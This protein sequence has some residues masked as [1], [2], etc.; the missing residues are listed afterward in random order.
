MEPAIDI[1]SSE[2]EWDSDELAGFDEIEE[3]SEPIDQYDT[4]LY[5][6]LTIGD[7]LDERYKIVHKLGW[8]GCSTVWMA[9]DTRE[10]KY[11]ALKILTSSRTGHTHGESDAIN[12]CLQGERKSNLVTYH[13]MFELPAGK[14]LHVHRVLVLPL[15]GPN[16]DQTCSE[17]P[18][19]THMHYRMSAAWQ[20]L[21]C[22]KDLHEAKIVH[23]GAAMWGLKCLDEY[24]TNEIYRRL[25]QPRHFGLGGLWKQ[26]DLVK[27]MTVPETLREDNI[28]LGDFGMAIKADT[29]VNIKIQTPATFCAPERFHATDPSF[30]SDMWSYMCIFAWLYLGYHPVR[31]DGGV[32]VISSMV[33]I[34]GPLPERWHGDFKY[35]GEQGD[36]G[37][38]DQSKAP[39]EHESLMSMAACRQ[40]PVSTEEQQLVV[41]IFEK[42][43]RYEPTYRWTAVQLL[44]DIDFIC[45]MGRYIPGFGG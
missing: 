29:A 4:K 17:M 2:E 36:N 24:D 28:C 26:G 6:P 8:G 42:V 19:S 43:F 7:V 32:S 10:R 18:M 41:R 15:L 25:G 27:S 23:R 33:S 14:N 30:A 40:P 16:L 13:S 9:H 39:V 44:E 38:Y 34:F 11:V 35:Y 3:N 20:L 45:L 12:E 5:Y 1:S 37:W 31:G 22:L 21:V